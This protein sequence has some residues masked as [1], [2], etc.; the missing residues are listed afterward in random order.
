MLKMRMHTAEA[1]QAPP[2]RSIL[3]DVR[4]DNRLMIANHDVGY[5]ASAVDQE[6]DLTADLIRQLGDGLA[7][8]WRNDKGR[9]G[10]A[11]VEIV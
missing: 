11:A 7:K 10:S 3:F 9:W 8:F 1:S 4:D 6:A 2:A 5:P